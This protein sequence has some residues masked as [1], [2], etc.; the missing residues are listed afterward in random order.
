M[1]CHPSKCKVVMV[2]KFSPPLII[3]VLPCVQF[4]YSMG[5]EVLDYVNSETDLGILIN[6]A[7]NF[8]E[9]AK[10]LYSR[11]NQRSGLMI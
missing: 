6:I 9:H 1:K 3:D 10:L 8:T 2:S 4:F 11:A 7:L 5:S